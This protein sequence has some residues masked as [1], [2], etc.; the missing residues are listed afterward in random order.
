MWVGRERVPLALVGSTRFPLRGDALF[1]L[2]ATV[3]L[4]GQLVCT[5]PA[6]RSGH[7]LGVRELGL[8]CPLPK[9][10]SLGLNVE[11]LGRDTNACHASYAGELEALAEHVLVQASP[12]RRCR[13]RRG[14]CP[15][16]LLQVARPGHFR[17]A[18]AVV[19]SKRG[20]LGVL[21]ALCLSK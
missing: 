9:G 14:G 7:R 19:R 12:E 16:R 6:L 5:L 21:V 3:F 20:A 10:T 17:L 4:Q 18:K 2:Y 8:D 15:V 1:L 11:V 13:L